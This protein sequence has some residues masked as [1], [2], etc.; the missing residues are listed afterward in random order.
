MFSSNSDKTIVLAARTFFLPQECFL[1]QKE[2]KILCQEKKT[3]HQENNYMFCHFNKKNF[4]ASE[5][6][7][8]GELKIGTRQCG[9]LHSATKGKRKSN[10]RQMLKFRASVYRLRATPFVYFDVQV[11]LC[12]CCLPLRRGAAHGL[13]LTMS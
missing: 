12:P 8:V 11:M 1:L 13:P 9:S 5:N 10:K 7:Y 4:L 2:T 6:I 3:F